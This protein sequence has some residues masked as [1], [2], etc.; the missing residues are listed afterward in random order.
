MTSIT[1][2][3][4]PDIAG[5]KAY[6][7]SDLLP[8][9]DEMVVLMGVS[10]INTLMEDF[11]KLNLLCGKQLTPVLLAL[12]KKIEKTVSA[13][14]KEQE[15]DEAEERRKLEVQELKNRWEQLDPNSANAHEL[16][17]E[18][19][20]FVERYPTLLALLPNKLRLLIAS[21]KKMQ[22]ALLKSSTNSSML[23]TRSRGSKNIPIWTWLKQRRRSFK[24][25]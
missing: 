13:L 23:G 2:A 1:N 9:I 21:T 20:A 14:Y 8:R 18:A 17:F 3:Q 24:R 22:D 4:S 11:A 5:M 16:I 7:E 12:R 6:L 10:K 25:L 15:A 19:Q